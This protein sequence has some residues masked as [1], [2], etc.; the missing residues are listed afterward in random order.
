SSAP[1]LSI[2]PNPAGETL[3]IFGLSAG[4]SVSV[5]DILGNEVLIGESGRSEFDIHSLPS[6]LYFVRV[7]QGSSR[8]VLKLLK[9]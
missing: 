8:T 6:G 4:A 2:A 9:N 7:A 1:N 3:H 5:R